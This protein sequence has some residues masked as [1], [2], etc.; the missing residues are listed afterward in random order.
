MITERKELRP[1]K[2]NIQRVK[3]GI[4]LLSQGQVTPQDKEIWL[5]SNTPKEEMP[6]LIAHE[7]SHSQLE[8]LGDP[9]ERQDE[10][11]LLAEARAYVY[12][13]VKGWATFG[14]FTY[15]LEEYIDE[16]WGWSGFKKAVLQ[17]YRASWITQKEYRKTLRALNQVPEYLREEFT[18]DS[19][20]EES[21]KKEGPPRPSNLSNKVIR[22]KNPRNPYPILENL[23]FKIHRSMGE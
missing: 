18:W 15:I 12:A 7:L 23:G 22:P 6:A 17:L 21:H 14:D 5:A 9:L 1:W 20:W 16:A 11:E 4:S 10:Q 8:T 19:R 2:I 13:Y 3:P